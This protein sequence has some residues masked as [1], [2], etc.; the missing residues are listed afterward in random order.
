MG[1]LFQIVVALFEK[2]YQIGRCPCLEPV[3]AVSSGLESV[4]DAEGI[5]HP[6]GIRA[7]MVS[8]IV[9]FELVAG[10]FEGLS[11]GGGKFLYVIAKIP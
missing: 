10:L 3:A 5:V 11:V 6:R 2:F 4:E 8:V 9:G 7:E 1:H